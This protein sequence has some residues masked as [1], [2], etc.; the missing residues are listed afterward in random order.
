ML[1]FQMEDAYYAFILCEFLVL[2]FFLMEFDSVRDFFMKGI[3]FALASIAAAGLSCFRLIPYYFSTLESPYQA[4][5]T[6]SPITK[7]SSTSS[8]CSSGR[9][10][11]R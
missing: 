7:A 10:C 11:L 2:Y 6:I 5:D 4:A 3:R 1:F 8:R 9:I